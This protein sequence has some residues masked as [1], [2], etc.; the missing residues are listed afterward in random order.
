M[1]KKYAILREDGARGRELK[2]AAHS[3]LK[4]GSSV[5]K[6]NQNG[7]N[8]VMPAEGRNPGLSQAVDI[9]AKETGPRFHRSD[10]HDIFRP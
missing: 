10:S 7:D 4:K 3:F 5:G 9:Q 8:N 1:G 6:R 2:N